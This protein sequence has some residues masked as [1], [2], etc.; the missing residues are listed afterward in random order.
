MK[1]I[2]RRSFREQYPA[3]LFKSFPT[4][5]FPFSLKLKSPNSYCDSSLDVLNMTNN[6]PDCNRIF[7]AA[8]V[9]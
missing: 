5:I 6:L 1:P 3:N 4:R 9:S 8:K 7:L 2:N